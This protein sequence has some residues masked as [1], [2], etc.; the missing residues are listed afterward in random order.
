MNEKEII[1][2]LLN[3]LPIIIIWIRMESRL[4]RLEGR[5]DVFFTIVQGTLKSVE[6]RHGL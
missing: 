2:A 4:S 3:I 5:F 6:K 1:L